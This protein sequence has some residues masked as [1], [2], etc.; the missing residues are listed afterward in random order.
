MHKN[1]STEE[2]SDVQL[3]ELSVLLKNLS[4]HWFFTIQFFKMSCQGFLQCILKLLNF[5][6]A[7]VGAYMVL[8]SL[9]MLKEWKFDTVSTSDSAI[10]TVLSDGLPLLGEGN[11]NTLG[12]VGYQELGRPFISIGKQGLLTIPDLPAPWYVGWHNLS[13]AF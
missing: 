6:V 10:T 13:V 5:L 4:I 7:M 8:Y 9:W 1:F 11:L 3:N 12:N 2:S